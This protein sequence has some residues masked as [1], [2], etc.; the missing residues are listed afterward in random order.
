VNVRSRAASLIPGRRHVAAVGVVLVAA[1]LMGA[2]APMAAAAPGAALIDAYLAEHGSPMLGSGAAFVAEGQA[3][4][5][6]PAFLV[7]IAGAETSF[8]RLLYSQDGDQC[9]YNAFNWFYGPTWP[10]SDFASWDEAI[11]AVAEGLAGE[12]YYGAGLSSVEAIAPRYCP[13]GTAAWIANVTTF[14]VEL[15]GDPAD[16]RL[17]AAPPPGTL[18]GLAALEG[19][20]VFGDGPRDVGETM[21]ATFTIVNRGG[22]P[23][24]LD[25]IRLAVRGPAGVSADMVSD[26]AFTL[27][28]GRALKVTA[29]WPLDLAGRWQGWIEVLKGGQP[30]PIGA[31]TAFSFRVSLPHN[32]ELRRWILR[33][34]ALTGLS[35]GS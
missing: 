19:S 33:D 7:A 12:L 16:T 14:V 30:S 26:Q 4:G 3:H 32:L 24:A 23:L 6:D 34:E 28:P 9:T 22:Q 21:A 18:P 31:Q 13:D 25:G 29:E 27:A 35:T 1:A 11:A 20:V 17:S 15:G 10:T 8:G 5:V 2:A